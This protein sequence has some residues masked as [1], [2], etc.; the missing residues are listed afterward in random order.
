MI[1]TLVKTKTKQKA[2]H[3]LNSH[4]DNLDATEQRNKFVPAH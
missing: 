1:I 3:Q 4:Q 2:D